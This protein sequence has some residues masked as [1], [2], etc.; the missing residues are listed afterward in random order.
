MK[1]SK[2]I[3][4]VSAAAVALAFASGA[5]AQSTASVDVKV[6][7]ASK[8]AWNNAAGTAPT[9][10]SVDFGTYT[11]FQA[12]NLPATPATFTVKCTRGSTTPTASWDT[13]SGTV[14][15][16]GYTLN[17]PSSTTAAGTAAS[18]STGAGADIVTFTLGGS[19]ASGQA[20]DSAAATTDTR[21]ITMSF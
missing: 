15:G 16:L 1:A 11:A 20:G 13:A 18:G 3:R 2:L 14:G 5:F 8:C 9:G 10:L 19:I 21:T 12:G 17:S 4:A 6:T 7:L